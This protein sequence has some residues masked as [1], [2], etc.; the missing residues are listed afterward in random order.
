[1]KRLRS[2]LENDDSEDEDHE[3]DSDH[4]EYVDKDEFRDEGYKEFAVHDDDDRKDSE[5]EYTTRFKGVLVPISS[6][7]TVA[8]DHKGNDSNCMAQRN[9][10]NDDTDEEDGLDVAYMEKIIALAGLSDG[11]R[12]CNDNESDNSSLGDLAELLEVGFIQDVATIDYVTH[13]D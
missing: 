11:I 13:T 1:L 4:N 10:V 2:I 6:P 7:L 9:Q 3:D 5:P 12:E 8:Q